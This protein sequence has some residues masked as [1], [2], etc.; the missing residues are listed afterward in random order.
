[1]NE[2]LNNE[3]KYLT[4]KFYE[5]QYDD[6]RFK[7]FLGEDRFLFGM[8]SPKGKETPIG[9]FMRYKTMYDTLR[10]LDW[11]IKISFSKG[12]EYAYS[13]PVREN[14][15]LIE[16]RSKEESLA[17]YYIENALFRTSTLWDILAQLYC[18]FYNIQI[19]KKQIYY[20]RL[21]NTNNKN[22]Y[23]LY[24]VDK[25]EKFN[26]FKEYAN[27]INNYLTQED[28]S[29][30]EGEW[31]GNHRYSNKCRNKM[32]H[33]NSPN[34]TTMSDYDFNFKD[35]PTFMLKRII[36]DYATVSKYINQILD[37]IEK[38]TLQ[39]LNTFI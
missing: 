6:E 32:T 7:L 39:N 11:K 3:I 27:T 26:D 18:L 5:V 17:Y 29:E 21:F 4:E 22:Y 8:T 12:I 15:S 19:P 1:M 38:D 2:L 9:N 13:N 36:E 20:N 16:T 23:S 24:S 28:D 35:H 33:R 14:F 30:L 10:D 34:I 37:I 25:I 31:N